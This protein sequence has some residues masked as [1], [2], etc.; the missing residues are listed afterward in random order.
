MSCL[1]P[2]PNANFMLGGYE[3]RIILFR[4][5]SLQF[6]PDKGKSWMKEKRGTSTKKK[7]YQSPVGA[8]GMQIC[9]KFFWKKMERNYYMKGEEYNDKDVSWQIKFNWRK[10]MYM[11]FAL[12]VLYVTLY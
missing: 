4:S 12:Y 8:F 11:F 5:I 10:I 2:T 1:V 7:T 3:K 6:Q 9:E